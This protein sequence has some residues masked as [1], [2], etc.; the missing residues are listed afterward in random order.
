MKKK[1]TFEINKKC[2][3]IN[4]EQRMTNLAI[5]C[6]AWV[7][8]KTNFYKVLRHICRRFKNSTCNVVY[9]SERPISRYFSIFTKFTKKY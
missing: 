2:S 9:Y 7:H 5:L 3:S 1:K 4:C 8:E 6:R